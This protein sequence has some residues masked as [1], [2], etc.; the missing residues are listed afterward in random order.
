MKGIFNIK[1]PVPRYDAVWDVR[2]VLN[3][4]RKLGPNRFLS[5]K[6]LTLKLCILL[7]LLTAQR[8]QTLCKLSLKNMTL[9][10]NKACFKVLDLVKTNRQ[11]LPVGQSVTVQAYPPDRRLCIRRLIGHYIER[12]AMFRGK[13]TQLLISYKQPYHKVGTDTIARWIRTI[14]ALSGIDVNL[15]KAHS[16]RAASVSAAYSKFLP[17]QEIVKKAGWT[18][19]KTF[20]RFYNKPVEIMDKFQDVILS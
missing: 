14:L 15:Y 7:A 1:P 19:E 17:I 2:L 9:S 10:A 13:E 3:F 5:L 18:N 12:T 6:M 4:L 8:C 16:V 11:G 20:Q